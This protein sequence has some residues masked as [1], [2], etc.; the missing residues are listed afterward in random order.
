MSKTKRN[1]PTE[2]SNDKNKNGNREQTKQKTSVFEQESN[3][4][5][6]D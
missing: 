2:P 6:K 4:R 1:E 3:S 5:T